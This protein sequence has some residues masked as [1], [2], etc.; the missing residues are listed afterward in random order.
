MLI[1]VCKV[2]LV[3]STTGLLNLPI[4]RRV[5]I[6]STMWCHHSLFSSSWNAGDGSDPPEPSDESTDYITFTGRSP[7]ELEPAVLLFDLSNPALSLLISL[8][9][10]A[11]RSNAIPS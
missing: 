7:P 6:A 4:A 2:P 1:Y 8:K 5:S 10:W 3:M 11:T 9:M